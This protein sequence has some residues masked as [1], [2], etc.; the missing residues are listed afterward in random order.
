MVN[1]NTGKNTKYWIKFWHECVLTRN[2]EACIENYVLDELIMLRDFIYQI[3]SAG[4]FSYSTRFGATVFKKMCNANRRTI[5]SQEQQMDRKN[6]IVI[7][8]FVIV[9]N[10]RLPNILHI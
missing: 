9:V 2:Y 6:L 8:D 10:L 4:N 5:K 3:S 1:K 7:L